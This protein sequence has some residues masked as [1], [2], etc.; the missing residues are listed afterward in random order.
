M[1][2]NALDRSCVVRCDTYPPFSWN[3]FL[4]GTNSG[5][6]WQFKHGVALIIGKNRG[7]FEK[8]RMITAG[9][10]FWVESTIRPIITVQDPGIA[11]RNGGLNGPLFGSSGYQLPFVVS[12]LGWIIGF[13]LFG[14]AGLRVRM[15]PRRA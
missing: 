5:R 11:G 4:S 8:S 6:A 2:R 12:S 13:F 1:N 14:I 15:S 10:L 9:S 3:Y 7:Y